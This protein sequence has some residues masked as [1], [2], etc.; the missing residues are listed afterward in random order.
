MDFSFNEEQSSLGDTIAQLLA[1]FPVLTGPELVP[2]QDAAV[3]D[4]LVELGLFTLLVPEPQ[5]GVGLALVDCALAIEALGGGLAPPLVASTLIATEVIVR[6][7]PGAVRNNLLA[8]ISSGQ[9]RIALAVAEGGQNSPLE[10]R[11]L[12]EDGR[13]TGRKIAVPGALDADL[14]LVL[15][16]SDGKPCVVL[17]DGA[18]S[19]VSRMA[20]ETLDPSASLGAVT[21]ADAEIVDVSS[22]SV[23]GA[24]CLLDIAATVEAG[25]AIG[26]A[27]QVFTRTVEYAKTRQ[28][29]GQ[30]IGAFQTIKHRCAD[31]AVALEA[32]RATA[33]YA[34]WACGPGVPDQSQRASSAKA[35]CSEIA[36]DVCNEAIQIHGGMGFTW[37]LGLHRYLRRVKILTHSLGGANWHYERVYEKSRIASPVVDAHRDAA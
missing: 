21:F 20:H 1:D 27:G 36:S 8:P 19:G 23:S 11:C 35:Y 24:E 3:W 32:G 22:A 7:L 30:P 6:C 37:E 31:M 16:H 33:Y 4:A 12:L 14:F 18:A 25:L 5:G 26:M 34:F 10:T 2:E 13:L 15:A 9:K 28:Q 17:V 29:F